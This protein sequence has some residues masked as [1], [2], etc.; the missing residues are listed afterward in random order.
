MEKPILFGT[1]GWRAIIGD[2]FTFANV[3]LCAQGIADYLQERG[4]AGPGI[5]VGYDTR[6]ASEEFATAV[7]EVLAA[8]DIPVL[9]CAEPAPTP[10]ISYSIVDRKAAGAVIITASHNPAL[11]NGV[12]FK[13]EYAGSA[14]PE[15]TEALERHIAA[16]AAGGGGPRSLPLADARRAGRVASLDPCP[17]YLRHIRSDLG[18]PIHYVSPSSPRSSTARS[19][20]S[21]KDA[22]H[23]LL[24]IGLA[25]LSCE[26]LTSGTSTPVGRQLILSEQFGQP[27]LSHSPTD[28]RIGR[29]VVSTCAR[30]PARWSSSIS[31]EDRC[32]SRLTFSSSTFP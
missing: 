13:P 12:K 2:A 11:W 10:V 5:I 15:V 16:V 28:Q 32:S 17:P 25:F 20:S 30:R 9:L 19:S 6:F 24:L 29:L 26:L 21:A 23:R 3:R 1:D 27:V 4:T 8:N 14:A 31:A 7:A 18:L 22:T